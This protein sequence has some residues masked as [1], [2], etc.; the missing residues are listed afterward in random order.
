MPKFR[1]ILDSSC[2]KSLGLINCLIEAFPFCKLSS[3]NCSKGTA[4]TMGMAS[5]NSWTFP[6]K[7]FIL[8]EEEIFGTTFEVS[9][10]DNN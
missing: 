3:D 5:L 8:C 10:F 7:F 1:G 9:S 2:D 6:D 4:S